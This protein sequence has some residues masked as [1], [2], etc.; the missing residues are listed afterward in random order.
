MSS[1]LCVCVCDWL[2]KQSNKQKNLKI[3]LA[4]SSDFFLSTD[5]KILMI[6]GKMKVICYL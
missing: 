5:W 2:K 3:H 6:N 4:T 1:W